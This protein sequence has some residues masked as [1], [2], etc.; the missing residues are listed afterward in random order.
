MQNIEKI[1]KKAIYLNFVLL[2]S[3]GISGA[4]TE[5]PASPY[6]LI[7]KS[8]QKEIVL[9]SNDNIKLSELLDKYTKALDP[10]QSFKATTEET[11]DVSGSVPSWGAKVNNQRMYSRYEWCTDL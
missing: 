10:I 11:A 9:D 3:I 1:F 7:S 6:E 2:I 4:S 5:R 8:L